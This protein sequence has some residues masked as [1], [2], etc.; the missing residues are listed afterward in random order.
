MSEKADFYDAEI[1]IEKEYHEARE[2]M[3][4]VGTDLSQ[5]YQTVLHVYLNLPTKCGKWE[6]AY[7]ALLR[8]IVMRQSILLK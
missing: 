2:L 3:G 6:M 1:D 4:T 7:Q 5:L 8:E